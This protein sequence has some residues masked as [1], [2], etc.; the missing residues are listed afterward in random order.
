MEEVVKVKNSSVLRFIINHGTKQ[1]DLDVR[2][3]TV[4]NVK[5]DSEIKSIFDT[6]LLKKYRVTI[7]ESGKEDPR[8][9]IDKILDDAIQK[10]IKANAR[11]LEENQ[12]D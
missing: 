9:F 4:K 12:H 10:L 6:Y 7:F 2:T 1:I 8:I 5:T 3:D 11:V